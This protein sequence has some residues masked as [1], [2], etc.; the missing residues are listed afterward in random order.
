MQ[1][2]FYVFAADQPPQQNYGKVVF[3]PAENAEAVPNKQLIDNFITALADF[4]DFYAAITDNEGTLLPELIKLKLSQLTAKEKED[5]YNEFPSPDLVTSNVNATI[6][7]Y[8]TSKNNFVPQD[9]TSIAK[10][11]PPFTTKYPSTDIK[12]PGLHINYFEKLTTNAGFKGVSHGE[13]CNS[14]FIPF[15]IEYPFLGYADLNPISRGID[16][17]CNGTPICA[18][19]A[20]L[21]IIVAMEE[22]QI[23]RCEINDDFV[24]QAE[25]EATFENGTFKQVDIQVTRLNNSEFLVSTTIN[26]NPVDVEFTSLQI[27]P[28]SPI[29]FTDVA[30]N[31]DR[32]EEG[33]Y[34][35]VVTPSQ[36]GQACDLIKFQVIDTQSNSEADYY[37]MT[38]FR[39]GFQN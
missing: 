36:A 2:D 34:R 24:T 3:V 27:S 17:V 39:N 14:E 19:A 37:G 23:L 35:V 9:E 6:A 30:S 29:S 7:A 25:V 32:V 22:D 28:I 8:E 20:I 11:T 21:N 18:G 4:V 15:L 12:Y 31:V 1:Y 16:T 13:R 26:G 33:I 38:I 10:L 5:L